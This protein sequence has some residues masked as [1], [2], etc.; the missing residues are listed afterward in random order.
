MFGDRPGVRGGEESVGPFLGE[1]AGLAEHD[2]HVG[3][4]DL[5]LGQPV[6][7]HRGPHAVELEQLRVPVLDHDRR[8]RQRGQIGDLITQLAAG[9]AGDQIDQGLALHAGDQPPVD[10]EPVIAARQRP[11]ERC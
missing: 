6:G 9:E 3:P 10:D 7:D 11:L 1:L 5:Q 2:R 8:T 4:A